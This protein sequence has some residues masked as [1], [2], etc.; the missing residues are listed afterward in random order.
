MPFCGVHLRGQKPLP[1]G[2]PGELR[3]LGDHVRKH[4]LDLGLRQR[5]VARQ[6]GVNVNT[7][8]N[9]E[10][11]RSTPVPRYVPGIIQFLGYVPFDTTTDSLPLSDRLKLYRR[12]RGLSQKRL[13]AL[14]GVDPSS[15]LYWEWGKSRPTAA[16]A[17]KIEELLATP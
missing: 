4:R 2:Y 10:V 12:I 17:R 13:A 11:G 14:L 5:D 7:V 9:W 16:H 15:V 6:L 3:T 8:T 1:A